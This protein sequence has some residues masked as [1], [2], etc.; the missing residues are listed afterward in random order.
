MKMKLMGKLLAAVLC[1]TMTAS[2]AGCSSASLKESEAADETTTAESDGATADA[3]ERPLNPTGTKV[4]V[5]CSPLS[6][7][8][9]NYRMTEKCV[10]KFGEDRIESIPFRKMLMYRLSY[11]WQPIWQRRD[12][13]CSGHQ[14]GSSWIYR[15]S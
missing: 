2:L 10:A 1:V 13:W 5:L 9:E 12:N 7:G 15:S 11:H 14:R 3:G 8:E 6:W 4:G